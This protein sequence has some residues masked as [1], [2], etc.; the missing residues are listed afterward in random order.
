[1][2]FQRRKNLVYGIEKMLDR[3]ANIEIFQYPLNIIGKNYIHVLCTS[4]A[5]PIFR[6]IHRNGLETDYKRRR[7]LTYNGGKAKDERRHSEG[8]KEPRS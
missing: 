7:K 3:H 2:D 5:N 1:M 4:L 8:M 6:S